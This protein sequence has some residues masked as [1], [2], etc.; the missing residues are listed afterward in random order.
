M[1][2]EPEP[3]LGMPAQGGQPEVNLVNR[4]LDGDKAVSLEL[5]NR[6][7]IIIVEQH[8]AGKT[9]ADEGAEATVVPI[10]RK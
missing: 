9:I 5:L 3:R 8:A 7:E 1:S 6:G 4:A 10:V 2:K